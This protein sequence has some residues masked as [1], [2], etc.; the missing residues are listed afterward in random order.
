MRRLW[1]KFTDWLRARLGK[2]PVKHKYPT[3]KKKKKPGLTRGKQTRFQY[4]R[5]WLKFQLHRGLVIAA[6]AGGLVFIVIWLTLPS[7]DTLDTFD[8]KPSIV[9]KSEDG[10]II[11]SFGDVYG[12]YLRFDELPKSLIDAVLATEDRNFYH[13]FG[14]DPF[15]LLRASIA[16]F[17][18]GHVVQGGSTITQQVAKNVF[19]SPQRS[20]IR[21]IRE[22]LLATKLE[23]RFTKEEILTIY[24]NRVY[25]GSG[26]YGVDAASKRYF[27]KPA[28]EMS[29]GES[30]ILAGMLK[31]PSR[32]APTNNP[33]LAQKRAE[34]VIMNMANAKYI[35]PTKALKAREELPDALAGRKNMASSNLYF[36]DWVMEQVPDYM[37]NVTEDVVVITTLRP[38]WQTLGEKAIRDNLDKDGEKL[39]VTQA[40]LVAMTPDGAI[41]AMIGGR[42]YGESQYNRATQALR[43]PGS[44]FK[45]F[46][47]LAG[48]E[49]GLTPDTIVDDSPITVEKW[50][51]KN[52]SG[53]S[54]GKIPLREAVAHSIN[55]VAVQVSEMAGRNQV[56]GMARRLGI[57]SPMEPVPS[58]ALGATE[59]NLLEITGAYAHLASD[60]RAVKP[61]GIIS[62]KTTGGQE[63]YEHED[64][65]NN[66]VLRSDIVGMMNDLLAGVVQYGTGTRAN[67]GRSMAG[68]TGTTS[69]YK[70]AWFMG[71]TPDLV[72]GVWVGN[73]NNQSMKK[74]TGGTLP[75][76]I[77]AAFMKEA[78]AKTPA[79]A[80]PI[81]TSNP[82]P[83]QETL[84]RADTV[85]EDG[86]LDEGNGVIIPQ[87]PRRGE[88]DDVELSE[89]FW[90]KLKAAEPR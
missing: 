66:I 14:V 38:D 74:V 5:A 54:L 26:N 20:M 75:A 76:P 51:P 85:H 8:K 83:W 46:V 77:W 71:Y 13:H 19:L 40:A 47:Y 78:L 16:N 57:T 56:I 23:W 31:A 34:Q 2:A 42:D 70:D 53:K 84:T 37:G 48:L 15:G 65:T 89:E 72:T 61:Y 22:M 1:Y 12:K 43:Q 33:K 29:L 25:L 82:L 79:R 28:S 49:A 68:K 9:I 86:E 44:S 69:D 55:T 58:I 39:G 63:I 60:G 4:A 21:K 90:R 10:Q 7:I 52:Y 73:D 32:Y 30:A 88:P 80:L 59:V 64:A 81:R 35:T 41:R 67:I 6:I 50:Q 45:L 18:A 36:G 3:Y 11:G 24:L 62:I 87:P 27:G 17:R